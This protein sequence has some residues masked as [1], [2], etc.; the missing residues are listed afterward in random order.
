MYQ[1]LKL[2]ILFNYLYRLETYI[3]NKIF[4]NCE[5]PIGCRID[6]IYSFHQH[7]LKENVKIK[8]H[9]GVFCNLQNKSFALHFNKK[10]PR[11]S[12][13]INCFMTSF[14]N[15]L[16]E[17]T[18]ELNWPSKQMS[19]LDASLDFHIFLE[20]LT[21][22]NVDFNLNLVNLKGFNLKL[23]NERPMFNFSIENQIDP[24]F[25]ITCI[26]CRI[27][28]YQNIDQKNNNTNNIR[29]VQSCKDF[30][31]KPTLQPF[32][33]FFQFGQLVSTWTSY[34]FSH[35]EYPTALCPLVF[36]NSNIIEIVLIGLIDTFYKERRFRIA[37]PTDDIKTSFD[38]NINT[39]SIFKAENIRID[40]TLLNALVF[41]KL[42]ELTL[43]GF[44]QSIET[45]LFSQ[46]TNL[47]CKYAIYFYFNF[48]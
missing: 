36:N 39:L 45:N 27:D 11:P 35:C 19:I 30:Q 33:S 2:I 1:Y 40:S 6:M 24:F 31:E 25:S 10:D 12:K 21:Y 42:R 5:L 20:F 28:F 4:Y 29:R 17:R 38:S 37:D 47:I 23:F 44:I 8:S 14:E 13:Y 7:I 34:R 18:F 9:Q 3:T 48:V 46:M 43:Y 16:E 22:F 41:R 15:P 32:L 26:N